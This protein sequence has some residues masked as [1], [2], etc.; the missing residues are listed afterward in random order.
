MLVVLATLA[1][2][3]GGTDAAMVSFIDDRS[4]RFKDMVGTDLDQTPREDAFCAYTILSDAVLWVEDA[5]LDPRFADSALVTG[6]PHIRFYAGA[7]ILGADGMRLGAVCIISPEPRARDETICRALTELAAK[8]ST[9][10]GPQPLTVDDLA[11]QVQ[12]LTV[13][14]ENAWSLVSALVRA[15]TRSA[16]VK[17]KA[18]LQS[19]WQE[20]LERDQLTGDALSAASMASLWSRL[21]SLDLEPETLA[22]VAAPAAAA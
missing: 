4:Q 5:H 7:P 19:E 2:R 8:A 12:G 15:M 16:P 11:L 22:P 18:Q 3:I 21:G 1:A 13:D 17:L 9:Q 6:A 14:L 20:R 10:L